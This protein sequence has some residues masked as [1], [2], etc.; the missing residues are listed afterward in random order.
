MLRRA[1]DDSTKWV[2][3]TKTM[4]AAEAAYWAAWKAG[5][6]ARSPLGGPAE[7]GPEWEAYAAAVAARARLT[8]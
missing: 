1:S 8:Q 3:A 5:L 4:R 6:V 2:A 7:V